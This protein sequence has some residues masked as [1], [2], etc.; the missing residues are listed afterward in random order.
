MFANP[1][2]SGV[3]MKFCHIVLSGLV[4]VATA[5]AQTSATKP[6]TGCTVQGQIVQEPGGRPIRKA[7][8]T[9]SDTV[10]GVRGETEYSTVTD[11]EGRF[12]FEDVKP[13]TY[14]MYFDHAAFVDAEKRHHGSGMLLSL[15]SGQEVKDLLFHM[16]PTAAI[17]GRVTDSDGDPV[18]RVS[19]E[20]IPYGRTAHDVFRGL[21]S[22]TDD[23]GEYR[24]AGLPPKRYLVFAQPLSQLSRAT[25]AKKVDKNVPVY[26][27]TYY[28]GT[29]ERSQA[30]PL[31]LRPGDE[32]PANIALSLVHPVHVRGVVSNLPAGA[33]DEVSVVLRPKGEESM[34]DIQ[35]WP[36]DKDGRFDIRGVLPGSYDILLMFGSAR[37]LRFMRGD[38]AVQVSNADV[39][40]LRI[41]P[42]PNGLVRGQFRMDN[43]GKID[44]SQFD[45]S[46]HSKRGPV[47]GGY[48]AGGDSIDAIYWDE[49]S[50]RPEVKSNGSFEV[51]DVPPDTYELRIGP[52]SKA[53]ENYFVKAV[54]LGG[55]DIADSGLAVGGATYSLDIVVSASGATVEGVAV[56]D[57]DKPASDVEVILIPDAKR[58]GRNDLYQQATT[59]RLGHFSLRGVN[60]GEYQVFAV[61][62]DVDRDEI[63]DPEFIRAHESLG[64]TIKLE[65]GD[66][67][68]LVV[69]LVA[70]TE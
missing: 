43:G 57:K 31:A 69:K 7:D 10:E 64:Q 53:L 18:P 4:L 1:S 30:V 66:H 60:P 23:T 33:S 40:G 15:E 61:D 70:S 11:V 2:A 27:M 44:W 28:P 17:T 22:Y 29:T 3:T 34:A 45:I 50:P 5:E 51:K 67:K 25:V 14:R 16:A 42:L 49:R 59:D 68:N 41:S 24:I 20:A 48:T 52:T 39:E 21:G 56:D 38:E 19:V 13:G 37:P 12:K 9:L 46:F 65:E 8:V 35:P 26:A 6:P 36:L 47:M 54:N 55:K 32:T 63:P 62:A 58:R